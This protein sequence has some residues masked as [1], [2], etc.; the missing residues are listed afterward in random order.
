MKLKLPSKSTYF[1][2]EKLSPLEMFKKIV[3]AVNFLARF[4]GCDVYTS[5]FSPLKLRFILC[6]VN[7]LTFVAMSFY[8]IFLFRDDLVRSCFCMISLGLGL[9]G[10]MKVQTFVFSRQKIFE[11]K[12]R[13]ETFLVNFN[14]KATSEMFESWLM[15]SCHVGILLFIMI[16]ALSVLF[17][18]HPIIFFFITGEKILHAGFELPGIDWHEPFGY[19]LNFVYDCSLIYTFVFAFV[20]TCFI[21]IFYILIARGQFELLK[22]LL[23]DVDDMIKANKNGKNDAKI[24]NQIKLITEM[25]NE[26]LE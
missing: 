12:D 16:S 8:D 11:L 6:L 1:K 25:H 3:I 21:N 23:E 22:I 5:N 17:L 26:L 4:V 2:S 24:K 7:C 14:T 9:Q 18:I 10:V 13:C 15:I 19:A 20:A